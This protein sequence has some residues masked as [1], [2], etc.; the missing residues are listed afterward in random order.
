MQEG[1]D[2]YLC[3]WLQHSPAVLVNLTAA[4]EKEASGQDKVRWQDEDRRHCH[5][6]ETYLEIFFL[7]NQSFHCRETNPSSNVVYIKLNTFFNS[8]FESLFIAV[9]LSSAIK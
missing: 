6:E 4:R 5:L 1:Y 7:T 3:W 8:C 2:L 9:I